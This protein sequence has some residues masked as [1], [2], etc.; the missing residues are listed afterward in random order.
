MPAGLVAV[1]VG[2]ELVEVAVEVTG[3]VVVE[4]TVEV[5]VEVVELLLEVGVE[6]AVELELRQSREASVLIVS[7]P[8]PRF[9]I[10]AVL[11]LRGSPPTRSL[12]RWA[13]AAAAVHCPDCTADEIDVSCA[14]R[15]LA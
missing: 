7:A 6:V 9:W 14:L 1:L 11:T 8:W 5:A 15:L 4:V 2:E 12:K 3:I 10:N 13:A